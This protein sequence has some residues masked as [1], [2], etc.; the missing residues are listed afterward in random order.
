M[1]ERLQ[2][3]M[4]SCGIASRRKC[5]E[6]I[7]EGRV[8]VNNSIVCELG[9]KIDTEIDTVDVDSV[10][11]KPEEEKV[12]I[13]LNKPVGIV[14]TVND[15]KGRKTIID[16]VKINKRIYPI[17][18]L[19]YD[20]SG[21]ILL[22]N[23]G[24]IYNKVIHPRNMINKVYEALVKGV[25]D[26]MAISKFQ[27]GVDI[28]GYTTA[29]AKF[30]VLRAREFSTEVKIVIHEGKNRQIRKMCEAIGHEVMSLKRISVGELN[31]NGIKPG[32]WR[33]LKDDEIKYLKSL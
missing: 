25:P 2:K 3:Y 16:L 18:R 22:T 28:G 30:I 10:T 1:I 31:L 13:I 32:E 21:L 15:E 12:Y 11:I 20:S 14:S 29:P 9:F 4:A 23:D 27:T 19:D 7:Q 33:Y 17:G 24:E 5:E 6:I 26:A 8:R